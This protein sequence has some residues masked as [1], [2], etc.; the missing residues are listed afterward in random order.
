MADLHTNISG[1][2][3]LSVDRV[4]SRVGEF[5]ESRSIAVHAD[6]NLGEL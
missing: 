5:G 4:D 6:V 2:M 1:R 3:L